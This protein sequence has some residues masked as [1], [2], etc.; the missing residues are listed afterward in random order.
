[1]WYCSWAEASES[2]APEARVA[3]VKVFIFAREVGRSI[4]RRRKR[5][6]ARKIWRVWDEYVYLYLYG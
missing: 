6:R 5:R 4:S 2:R 3:T 1:M